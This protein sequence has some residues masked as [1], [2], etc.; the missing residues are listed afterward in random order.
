MT[1]KIFFIGNSFGSDDGIGP[2]LFNVLKD[3]KRLAGFELM[4]MGVIG[5]DL[6]SY[7]ESKDT[8]IVVDAVKIDESLEPTEDEEH[9]GEVVVIEEEDLQSNVTLV[10]QHDFG[11]EETATMMRKYMPNLEKICVVGIK[12][13]K[14]QPFGNKLSKKLHERINSIKEE[15]MRNILDIANG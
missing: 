2:Y 5:F 1:I 15:V 7:I 3:D 10:S 12:V 6:L 4:E 14:L 8:V 9:V 11:V 13:S